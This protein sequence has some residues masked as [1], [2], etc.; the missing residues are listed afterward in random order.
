MSLKEELQAAYEAQD[1]AKV[2]ELAKQV[3]LEEVIEEADPL[4]KQTPKRGRRK[5]VVTTEVKTS[6]TASKSVDHQ[7]WHAEHLYAP[8]AVP[9]RPNKFQPEKDTKPYRVPNQKR[10]GDFAGQVFENEEAYLKAAV[11]GEPTKHAPP[12]AKQVKT[13]C[14]S[15]G[16]QTKMFE[17]ELI[18]HEEAGGYR[19]DKCIVSKRKSTTRSGDDD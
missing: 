8:I 18:L 12:P 10:Y 2:A 11:Y 17:S 1:W 5:K 13:N 7:K 9:N 4:A 16:K 15:C 14:S 19:C 6:K 3:E